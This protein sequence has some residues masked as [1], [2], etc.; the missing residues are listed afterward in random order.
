MKSRPNRADAKH[1]LMPARTSTKS[2]TVVCP[3]CGA[4]IKAPKSAGRQRVR[5]PKCREAV[6]IE[7]PA[8]APA[9]APRIISP[10]VD[11]AA[12]QQGRIAILEARVATLE[13]AVADA[14]R[15]AA[16]ASPAQ[17]LRWVADNPPP[18]FSP[19][20]AEVLRHNLSTVPAH[21]ITIQFP[22]ADGPAR[23]HA[24]WFREV[25]ADAR[26]AVQ[27]PESTPATAAGRDIAFASCLPVSR[28][29]A[30]TYLALRA[31]GFPLVSAFDSGLGDNEERLVVP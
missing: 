22:A 14:V 11:E 15:A 20:Q 12:Q 25:F 6:V 21:R 30:A 27:G 18:D 29:V 31:A 17:Q 1:E 26:W 2:Q 3:A 5:C 16:T 23:Q 4:Q 28:D 8:E 7:P 9:D 10:A 24:E 13:K 19:E